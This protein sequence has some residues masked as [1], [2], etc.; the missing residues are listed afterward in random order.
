VRSLAQAAYR[1]AARALGLYDGDE[2]VG[3]LLLFDAR[4]DRDKPAEQLFVWRLMIDARCQRLGLGRLAMAWV[5]DEARRLG[6]REIGL[7]HV[8]QPGHAGPFYEKLGFFYTGVVEDGEHQM[9]LRLES[10]P[11][12]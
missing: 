8:M 3:F 9:L 2:P 6:L 5:I 11:E 10:D 12:A 4:L 1:P 7:S